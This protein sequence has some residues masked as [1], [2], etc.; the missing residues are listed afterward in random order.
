MNPFT[1]YKHRRDL[2]IITSDRKP[3]ETYKNIWND[4]YPCKLDSFDWLKIKPKAL[5]NMV[6]MQLA[7]M[8]LDGNKN[9]FAEYRKNRKN[10][11]KF[12]ARIFDRFDRTIM[13]VL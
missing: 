3:F 13:F 8:E 11:A 4:V 5:G 7:K 9:L 12:S 1:R 2:K 6:D 10:G